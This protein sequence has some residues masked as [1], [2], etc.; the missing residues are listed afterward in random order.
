MRA[1]EK[2]GVNGNPVRW[3]GFRAR[4]GPP[5][6]LVIFPIIRKTTREQIRHCW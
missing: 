3:F 1:G 5:I 6:S 2:M 4:C